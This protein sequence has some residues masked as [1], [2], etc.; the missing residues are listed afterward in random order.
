MLFGRRRRSLRDT[1]VTILVCVIP[2]PL[3]GFGC[4]RK[5]R[6]PTLCAQTG[7]AIC[8]FAFE[9]LLG[10]AT[11]RLRGPSGVWET[12]SRVLRLL[13]LFGSVFDGNERARRSRRGLGRKDDLRR[14]DVTLVLGG[15]DAQ[16]LRVESSVLVR[17]GLQT[18]LPLDV[19]HALAD[20]P[21]LDVVWRR[22][23]EH[24]RMRVGRRPRARLA[25]AVLCVLLER[26]SEV[27]PALLCRRFHVV[28]VLVWELEK[29]R[30]ERV[31]GEFTSR[32]CHGG[33]ARIRRTALVAVLGVA[34]SR[35][36]SRSRFLESV[37][38][39]RM[40]EVV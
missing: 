29:G 28:R 31:G 32:M 5:R 19:F 18:L 1:W 17:L 36:T 13:R 6:R 9:A 38:S 23:A 39:V 34:G 30:K 11:V 27:H 14:L 22:D 7:R 2:R 35:E 24:G 16:R 8:Q 25:L 40:G 20:L 33:E 3:R 15:R 12:R 4:R 26:G 10:L 21:D 37:C